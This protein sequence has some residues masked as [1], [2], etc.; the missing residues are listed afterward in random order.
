VGGAP[1]T[2]IGPLQYLNGEFSGIE[3]RLNGGAW[4]PVPADGVVSASRGTTVELRASLGNTGIAAWASGG[5]GT[6]GLAVTGAGAEMVAP[7]KS[8]IKRYRDGD[9]GPVVVTRRLEGGLGLS[10]RLRLSRGPGGYF[11]EARQVR[12]VAR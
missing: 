11:G 5:I 1:Y 3:V 8:E 6:I 10:L 12:V 9:F 4:Q 2:G 7:L